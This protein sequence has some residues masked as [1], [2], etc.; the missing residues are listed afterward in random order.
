MSTGVFDTFRLYFPFIAKDVVESKEYDT[1][2][3]VRLRNGVSFT[4]DNMTHTIRRLPSNSM[5]LTEDECRKEFGHRLAKIMWRKNISQVELAQRS[6]I[7]Q[8]QLS[9]YITG[10]TSPSFYNVDKIARALDCSTDELRY[11]D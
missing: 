11:I 3:V 7:T 10:K 5:S 4:Y 9:N 2:L 8:S 1:E 6:G